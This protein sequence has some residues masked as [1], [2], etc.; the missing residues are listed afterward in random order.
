MK[1]SEGFS[2]IELMIV[3]AIIGILA[4]V[5][6][7]MYTDHLVRSRIADGTSQLS[8]YKT[9]ME[10]FF[11]D[12]RTYAG[13]TI[14]GNGAAVPV[15]CNGTNETTASIY[16]DFICQAYDPTAGAP[17]VAALTVNG[18]SNPTAAGFLLV[19]RGKGAMANFNLAVD[20][21]GRRYS[22]HN[23]AAFNTGGNVNCWKS[24]RGTG[25]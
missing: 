23:T 10:Q 6:I 21:M 3:V 9:L 12:N 2:L 14:W 15:A 1:K 16:F 7:P 17:T 4:A 13:A 25:C 18:P 20:N 8:T 19:A 11:A 5:A 22:N 24:T